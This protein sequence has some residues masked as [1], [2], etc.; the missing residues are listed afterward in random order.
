M[1]KFRCDA[2]KMF[3]KPEVAVVEEKITADEPGRVRYKTTYWPAMLFRDYSSMTL[4]PG[5]EIAVV[6]RQGITLLV[7]PL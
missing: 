6:G 7:R 4:Y 3:S 2:P 1:Q 5:Q